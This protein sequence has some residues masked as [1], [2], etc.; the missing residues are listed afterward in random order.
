MR[1]L[2]LIGC[3]RSVPLG[4]FQQVANNYIRRDGWVIA[5]PLVRLVCLIR[6]GN[7]EHVSGH[8]VSTIDRFEFVSAI[9]EGFSLAQ[10]NLVGDSLINQL[11]N[12]G[13]SK[14]IEHNLLLIDVIA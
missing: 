2:S 6:R 1:K 10:S 14:S 4:I 11:I 7:P 9:D 3:V 12:I 8:N 5:L 13:H